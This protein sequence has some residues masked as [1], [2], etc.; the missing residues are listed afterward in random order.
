MNTLQQPSWTE[1]L[2]TV[3]GVALLLCCFGM[4]LYAFNKGFDITDEGYNVQLMRSRFVGTSNTYFF[5]VYRLLFGWLP[6][7]LWAFRLVSTVLLFASNVL[8][9][10]GAFRYFTIPFK[11]LYVAVALLGIPLSVSLDPVTFSYNYAAAVFTLAAVGLFL[12]AAAADS[13]NKQITFLVLSGIS[14]AMVAMC[15][16]TGG[17]ALLGTLGILL[18]FMFP[19]RWKAV[20]GFGLGWILYQSIHAVFATPFWVQLQLILDASPIFKQ[21]DPHYSPWNMLNEAWLF[22]RGQ[23][24]L[25]LLFGIG[26]LLYRYTPARWKALPLAAVAGYAW[27]LYSTSIYQL[28]GYVVVLFAAF[29]VAFSIV[30]QTQWKTITFK[31]LK[32]AL[33]LLLLWSVPMIVSL[34][35][36]NNFNYN[37]VFAASPLLVVG[38]VLLHPK[39]EQLQGYAPVLLLVLALAIGHVCY[40]KILFQPYRI[41]PLAQQTTR[42]LD[43]PVL[44]GTQLDVVSVQRFSRLKETMEQHGFTPGKPVVCLGKMQGVMSVLETSSPGGV[45]FSPVFK[46]L[47]LHN[48]QADT[49]MYSEPYF[50]ISDAPLYSE[51]SMYMQDN[52]GERFT[53]IL[54]QKLNHEM[55]WNLIDSV[56][57]ENS[58]MGKLYL[59]V[60]HR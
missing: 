54:S 53:A 27:Y 2:S 51:L 4:Q 56:S 33:I 17:M 16:I 60:S 48:L 26:W 18:F 1:K 24:E 23:L 29:C 38:I 9:V 6:Y 50:I 5:E 25:C 46:E 12:M 19:F 47:Y 3:G 21:M 40:I 49:L 44:N 20:W 41:L 11:P 42:V 59:Y 55:Q 39:R 34:G 30:H 7:Q 58:P 35:T 37:Y 8:V 28:T 32:D 31:Q 22:T 15:K 13:G 57:F 45:M 36:N 10:V 14:T 43:L 52:W